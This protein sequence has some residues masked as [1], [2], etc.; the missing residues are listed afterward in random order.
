MAKQELLLSKIEEWVE[1]MQCPNCGAPR[2]GLF[3]VRRDLH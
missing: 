1:E 2:D 3:P